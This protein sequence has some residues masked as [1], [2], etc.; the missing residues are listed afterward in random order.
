MTVSHETI[1]VTIVGTAGG[2][3][4]GALF[5]GLPNPIAVAVYALISSVVAW[6]TAQV[7]AIVKRKLGL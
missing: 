2:T 7:L 5:L 1:G 3:A 6:L 4:G